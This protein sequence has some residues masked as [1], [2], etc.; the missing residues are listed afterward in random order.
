MRHGLRQRTGP[1]RSDPPALGSRRPSVETFRHRTGELGTPPTLSRRNGPDHRNGNGRHRPKERQSVGPGW[2]PALPPTPTCRGC[3]ATDME[4]FA[5]GAG[6]DRKQVRSGN[7]SPLDTSRPILSSMTGPTLRSERANL[8][9]FRDVRQVAP[10][11]SNPAER[12]SKSRHEGQAASSV[13]VL[14]RGS[15][16]G[17]HIAPVLQGARTRVVITRGRAPTPHNESLDDVGRRALDHTADR[18]ALADLPT[19]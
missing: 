9:L 1:G 18:H 16:H 3:D 12:R 10:P 7:P 14:G 13:R 17:R 5:C 11:R 6:L 15:R 8:C 2:P 19:A 4:V